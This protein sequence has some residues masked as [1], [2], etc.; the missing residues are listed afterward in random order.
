MILFKVSENL[1][2]LFLWKKRSEK[3]FVVILGDVDVY[4]FEGAT[5]IIGHGAEI[6]ISRSSNRLF[7]IVG[8]F[9]VNTCVLWSF[10]S[11][12]RQFFLCSY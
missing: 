11:K 2:D 7:L 8:S 10:V 3:S 4:A 12:L 6:G 1:K 5:K 9:V